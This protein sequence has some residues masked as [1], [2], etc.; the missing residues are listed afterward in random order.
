[1]RRNHESVGCRRTPSWGGPGAPW[2]RKS[3][4]RPAAGPGPVGLRRPGA[5]FYL[6]VGICGATQPAVAGVVRPPEKTESLEYDDRRGVWVEQVPPTPGTP[7]GDLRLARADFTDGRY[8]AAYQGI[9]KWIKTYGDTDPFYPE[10]A[11]L[12]ARVEI[13]RRDHYKAHKHLQEFLNEF[14]G[15]PAAD[16]AV[17]YE[18][19]IADVF[20]KGT[21]RKVLGV[22]LLPGE[23][24]GIRI[25]DDLAAN[26][27]QSSTAE[28]ALKTKADHFF[29]KGD[30]ALAEV[31]YARMQEQFPR[32]RYFRHAV[33][34]AADA[35]LASFPGIEF[36]D[37]ALIEAESRY[38][39]YLGQY[40]GVAEQEGVGLILDNIR[41]Q[42]AAKELNIG[43][44]YRRTKQAKAAAFYY[45]STNT[46]W[47]ETIAAREASRRLAGMGLSEA[48]PEA[49][50]ATGTEPDLPSGNEEAP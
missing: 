16:E 49:G 37:A 15:T 28:L 20:L 22:P 23:D 21:K 40:P 33:R 6:F 14:G 34:R 50:A 19:V 48:P 13:A 44:Y 24:I 17:H 7:E 11:V 31:E 45:R 38:R 29:R 4:D 30:F 32:S 9:R 41:E 10:A 12:R 46:N 5:W 42:R 3:G 1:M 18:F 2:L 47:P 26:Y 27:P 8:D 39:Q 35:A 36:D 25:L 43:D